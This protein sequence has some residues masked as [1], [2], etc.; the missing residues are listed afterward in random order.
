M[1][2]TLI[3]V[4]VA[5]GIGGG[6]YAEEASPL[7][8]PRDKVSYGVG[9]QIGR[10]LLRQGML[11]DPEVLTR[12]IRDALAQSEPA[13]SEAEFAAAMEVFQKEMKALRADQMEKLGRK[14]LAE[15]PTFLAENQK[16]PGVQVTKSGL[17]YEVLKE[18]TGHGYGGGALPRAAT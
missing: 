12:G 17:Q 13:V 16:K 18:G 3:A 4:L 14:N 6:C 5:A 2:R 9:M 10:N 1:K 7:S 8:S 15:G 11:V